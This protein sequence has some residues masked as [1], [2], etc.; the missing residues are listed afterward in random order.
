MADKG[1][2]SFPE[3][4]SKKNFCTGEKKKKGKE[5]FLLRKIGKAHKQQFIKKKIQMSKYL[6][7][8]SKLNIHQRNICKL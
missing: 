1:L 3:L 2:R 8:C 4:Y 5:K 7:R 6:K